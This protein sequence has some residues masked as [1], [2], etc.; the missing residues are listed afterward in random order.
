METLINDIRTFCSANAMPI[1]RFGELA[2]RDTA[3][4]LKLERGRRVWPETEAKARSFMA[5]YSQERVA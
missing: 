2:L 4:V 3:F 5:T 1:T